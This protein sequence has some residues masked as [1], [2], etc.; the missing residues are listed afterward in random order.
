MNDVHLF[1]SYFTEIKF[2]FTPMITCSK[3]LHSV[4]QQVQLDRILSETDSPYFTPDEVISLNYFLKKSQ[5]SLMI[6]LVKSIFTFCSS[7]Y[8][9]QCGRNDRWNSSFTRLRRCLAIKRKCSSDL[10]CLESSIGYLVLLSM[11]YT[12]NDL[13]V[14]FSC[15]ISIDWA[16]ITYSDQR[17][18][19]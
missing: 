17:L 4:L 1:T 14:F 19:K 8:G 13:V 18:I 3:F 11:S 9:L 16:S 6:I 15:S 10:W 12:S 5:F 2:G 7:W